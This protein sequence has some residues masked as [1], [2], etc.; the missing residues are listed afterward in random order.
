MLI[1]TIIKN[2][3]SADFEKYSKVYFTRQRFAD[4]KNKEYGEDDIV[5][6]F[7]KNGYKILSPVILEQSPFETAPEQLHTIPVHAAYLGGRK[8]FG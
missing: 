4:A 7:E 3:S 6:F 5:S 8:V 2:A 1:D